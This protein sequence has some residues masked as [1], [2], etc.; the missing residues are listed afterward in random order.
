MAIPTLSNPDAETPALAV[1]GDY[2]ANPS[3]AGWTFVGTTGV[4]RTDSGSY[5]GLQIFYFNNSYIYQSFTADGSQFRLRFWARRHPTYGG[6]PV[7]T[8]AIGGTTVLTTPALGYTWTKYE[9]GD[10]SLSAGSY[11]LRFTTSI[12]QTQLDAIEFFDPVTSKPG[13]LIR[14]TPGASGLVLLA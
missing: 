8:V 9:T 1:D 14:L 13:R 6:A 11:Y 5:Q 12:N 7:L 10:L 2:V 4:V 3:G